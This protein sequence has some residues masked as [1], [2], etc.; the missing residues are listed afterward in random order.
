MHWNVEKPADTEESS[1]TEM[2][3]TTQ[4]VAWPKCHI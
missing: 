3:Y 2:I 1:D 4:S